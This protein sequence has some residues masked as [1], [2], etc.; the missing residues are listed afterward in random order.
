MV[1]TPDEVQALVDACRYPPVGKRGFGPR[2]AS[3]YYRDIDTYMARANDAIFVMPQIE[4]MATIDQL[5]AFAAVPG[6]DALCIG[7][8]DLSGTAGSSGRPTTHW[9]GCPGQDQGS[10]Q[11]EGPAGL[12]RRQH[13]TGAPA[14]AGRGRRRILLVT[15]TSSS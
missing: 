12:P 11:G 7:P 14:G 15:P 2:R 10:R 5:D 1:R 6:I 3:N 4:D 9:S 8:N 13:P